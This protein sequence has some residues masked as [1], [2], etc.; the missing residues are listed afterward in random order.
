VPDWSVKIVPVDPKKPAGS[1]RF[2]SPGHAPGT[3]LIAE[4]GDVVTWNNTT[5]AEHQPWPTDAN[6]NPL[7][8]G[9]NLP[10]YMSDPIPARD[11]ST[12]SY[13]VTLD[14]ATKPQVFYY[15]CKHH[16]NDR[17][18]RSAINVSPAS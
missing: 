18:E 1:A 11:S 12:P 2:D 7:P 10:L 16:P 6:Y 5:D 8:S 3:P 17:N 15:Y 13:P 14:D 4:D 9:P